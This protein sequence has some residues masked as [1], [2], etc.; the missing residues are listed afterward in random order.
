[1]APVARLLRVETQD[2]AAH[3]VEVARLEPVASR[4]PEVR[5]ALVDMLERAETRAAEAQPEM[6]VRQEVAARPQAAVRWAAE[7]RRELSSMPGSAL[8][9][10]CPL[11]Q[12]RARPTRTVRWS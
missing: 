4:V 7:G 3:K 8:R 12:Q 5:L 2:A 9:Q 10:P 11:M 6:V 1:M